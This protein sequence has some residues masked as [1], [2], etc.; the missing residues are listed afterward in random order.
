[1]PRRRLTERVR[2]ANTSPLNCRGEERDTP[3]AMVTA[4]VQC[5]EN[6]H[7]PD[8]ALRHGTIF[9]ELEKPILTAEGQLGEFEHYGE[10]EYDE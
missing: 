10:G 2:A 4:P 6:V 1:M 5:F 7:L 9:K 3:L 8:V